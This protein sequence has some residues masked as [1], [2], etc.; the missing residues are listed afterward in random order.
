MRE[1]LFFPRFLKL[2]EKIE[3]I[4]GDVYE[5]MSEYRGADHQITVRHKACGHEWEVYMHHLKRK[6]NKSGEP[7]CPL[8]S[9]RI[10]YTKEVF[11]QFCDK[12]APNEYVVLDETKGRDVSIRLYHKKC[13]D[14]FWVCPHYF[15]LR[16]QR[17]LCRKLEGEEFGRMVAEITSEEYQ[18][19]GE[20]KNKTTPIEMNHKLCGKNIFISPYQFIC[21]NKRC[22]C[23]PNGRSSTG[24]KIILNYLVSHNLKYKSEHSFNDCTH[25]GNLFFDFAIFNAK[26]DVKLLIEFD[27]KQHF[28]PIR[29]F[30]GEENFKR[31]QIRDEIKNKYCK[32]NKI[33]LL[34]IPYWK[35]N[36]IG[37]ILKEELTKLNII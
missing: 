12:V 15:V 3:E 22:D 36:N 11:Q 10:K 24:E 2:K 5:Y 25:I 32:D 19:N 17:C 29:W 34:R 28:E 26:E 13:D 27:G 1:E 23:E 20:Y 35:Q 18:I 14:V 31:Q 30:G 6:D 7:P 4:H 9:G 33:P 37:K 8:C 16:G 21:E